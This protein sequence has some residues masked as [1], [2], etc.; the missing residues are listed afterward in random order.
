MLDN[1]CYNKI[2]IMHDLSSLLWFV[3]KHAQD[4]AQKAQ[5]KACVDFLKKLE[6]DLSEHLRTL[7][8]MICEKKEICTEC[9]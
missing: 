6:Q 7:K 5:D 4:D 8:R 9:K 1:C 2:K 3:K